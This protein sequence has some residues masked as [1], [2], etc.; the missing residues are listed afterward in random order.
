M[1]GGKHTL[2]D[3]LGL[4]GTKRT[5]TDQLVGINLQTSSYGG[6]LPLIYGT[7]RVTGNLVDY[8][9]FV[10]HANSTRT[11]KGGSVSTSYTYS[12]G[13]ILALCEGP[14]AG[15]NRMWQNAAENTLSFYGMTVLNGQRPQ[16]PWSTWQTNHPIKAVGYPGIALACNDTFDMGSNASLPTNAFEV[17]ALLATEP[18]TN[19]LTT[20]GLGDTV[21]TVFY[22]LDTN[23][24]QVT[25]S[26][27]PPFTGYI[28]PGFYLNGVQQTSGFTVGKV[29]NAYAITF[30]IAPPLNAVV[31]WN[32]TEAIMNDAKPSAVLVDFLTSPIHGVPGWSTSRISAL[33]TGCPYLT[34]TTLIPVGTG[35]AST[36]VFNL[37]TVAGAAIP[38]GT[39]Y[40]DPSYYLN[41]IQQF[42]G[43][44]IVNNG[45]YVAISFTTAPATGAVIAWNAIEEQEET[46]VQVAAQVAWM[47]AN[48]GSWQT[49]C[50]AM[51]FAVSPAFDQQKA[52]AEHLKDLFTATNSEPICHAGQ[53]G[54]ELNVIPYGDTPVTANGVT[55]TPN[56]T[57]LYSLTLDDFL[58]AVDE[59]G[60]PS[61][62][63][64]VQVT[65]TSTS[66][67]FNAI[68]VEWWDRMSAYNVS[69]VQDP[70]PVDTALH[71]TKVGSGLTLHM[72]CRR[73]MAQAVSRLQAQRSVYIRNQY[74]FKVGWRFQLLEPMDF[75]TISDP[76]LGLNALLVRIVSVDFP[77]KKDESGG[78]TITAE[79]WP[80]GVG[81]PTIYTGQITT[82]PVMNGTVDPGASNTPIIMDVPA[83]FSVSGGP[84]L[85]IASS[86][87]PL[88]GSAQVWVSL[89]GTTYTLAGKVSGPCLYGV[90]SSAIGTTGGVQVNL[91]ASGGTLP[92][93]TTT[94]ATNL[95]PMMWVNGELVAWST[96][97]LVSSNVY[98]LTLPVRGAYGTAAA[99]QGSGVPVLACNSQPFR[100]A[101]PPSAMGTLLYF[102]LVSCNLWGG[103]GNQTLASATVYTHT[104]VVTPAGATY[105]TFSTGVNLAAGQVVKVNGV[106]VLG[107][108]QTGL[109]TTLAAYTY[110]GSYAT[111]LSHV[112]AMHNKVIALETIIRNQGF[113]TT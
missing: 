87:G 104:P 46:T 86:G 89:D 4:F 42:G 15:I 24:A 45:G 71:G 107:G 59:N 100:Y 44:T 31:A 17:Q 49:Y 26:T 101:V 109:G 80:V 5:S 35:N 10:T 113:G 7:T 92:S 63:D 29:S 38:W 99:A 65:R 40:V 48:P 72:I 23:G 56:T 16:F 3:P 68:P 28:N 34:S 96:A 53:N 36:T 64:P 60:D 21:R 39:A 75:I 1:G 20:L 25:D 58:G 47:N 76:F 78:I 97:T 32:T 70:E 103:N 111:D 62:D 30:S 88:W 13:A 14:I 69:A 74:T 41:G 12:A 91:G 105:G 110:S 90:T 27:T 81:T 112:Q 66:D 19:S 98:T 43:F 37:L 8:D 73:A 22:L 94:Q 2:M 95:I 106:Q 51:G 11:G 61:G 55:Y 102:K 33:I 18:D 50:T 52:A 108:Q 6:S 85:L 79:A 82:Q 83:Q 84:E 54:M 9:D 57:P 67:V 93:Y 77:E